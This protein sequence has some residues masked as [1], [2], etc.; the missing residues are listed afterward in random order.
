MRQLLFCLLLI[1][2]VISTTFCFQSML[3]NLAHRSLSKKIIRLNMFGFDPDLTEKKDTQ[4]KEDEDNDLSSF[5]EGLRSWPLY[6]SSERSST[7]GIPEI[8][9]NEELSSSQSSGRSRGISALSNLLKFQV[10]LDLADGLKGNETDDYFSSIITAADQL[11][12]TYNSKESNN[13]NVQQDEETINLSGV[14]TVEQLIEREKWLE[15]LENIAS[16]FEGTE[17][18]NKI[19]RLSITQSTAITNNATTSQQQSLGQAAE[20]MMKDATSRI[21]YLVNEASRTT[22]AIVNDLVFRSTQV[23]SNNSTTSVEQL[24][25]DIVDVAENIAKTRG[26]DVQYA[27]DRAREA[28]KG[29]SSMV[30]VANGL[31][32]SGY[33]YGSRSG[34]A[35]S[36]GSSAN[37]DLSTSDSKPLFADFETAQRIEP[38][39]YRAV[40]SKGA[41][42]GALAGAIYENT[43]ERTHK[44]GHSVVANGTTSDVAWLITDS[45]DFMASYR[46]TDDMRER[47]NVG[48]D[49]PML[50]RTI[51]LRGFDA[52]DNFVDRE[53]LLNEICKASGASI[54]AETSN[55]L[56]HSGLLEIAREIYKDTKKYIDWSSPKHR[57]VF[58]GHSIGGS[59][60]VL[61]LLLMTADKG[62]KI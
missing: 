31:F 25:N 49:D 3:P 57:I 41:E 4:A 36:E 9:Q 20:A 42:M 39:Q 13:S 53:R 60:S 35:G 18:E 48:N 16:P 45:I 19:A 5:F 22:P 30:N 8:N 34:V 61:M 28:T 21:E 7:S 6:P 2:T 26:L 10:V 46:E 12:K 58:N 50:V 33:A 52:S 62:G 11:F 51:T 43:L 32:A 1:S 47:G 44:L 29:A 38:F 14:N 37:A 56:F 55:I 59:L 24:T 17:G 40:V 23:F 15:K 54:N 27:A